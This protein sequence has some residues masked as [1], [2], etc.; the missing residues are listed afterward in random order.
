MSVSLQTRWRV[1]QCHGYWIEDT[2][3]LWCLAVPFS[4]D[5]ARAVLMSSQCETLRSFSKRIPNSG[6]G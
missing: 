5:R 4:Q 3:S 6:E 2:L 1:L